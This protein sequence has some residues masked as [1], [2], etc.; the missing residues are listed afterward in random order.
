[1]KTNVYLVNPSDIGAVIKTGQK[2]N[3]GGKQ[4]G[5]LVY[6]KALTLPEV[7]LELEAVA[8]KAD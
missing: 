8:A 6:V 5:T 1:M 4:T 7:L 2:H 3:P